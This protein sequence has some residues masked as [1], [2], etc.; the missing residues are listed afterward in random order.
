MVKG[1]RGAPIIPAPPL[2]VTP[3]GAAWLVHATL[4]TR[5]A[6]ALDVND[7]AHAPELFWAADVK[8]SSDYPHLDIH[9]EGVSRRIWAIR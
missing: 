4:L 9:T 6:E 1:G 7:A 8:P 3:L 5:H 2:P